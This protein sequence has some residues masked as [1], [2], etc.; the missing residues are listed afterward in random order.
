MAYLMSS[1]EIVVVNVRLPSFYGKRISDINDILT[2]CVMITKI[3]TRNN[4]IT[5]SSFWL[6]VHHETRMTVFITTGKCNGTSSHCWESP[7]LSSPNWS[8]RWTLKDHYKL[9]NMYSND[10]IIQEDILDSNYSSTLGV[11][12]KNS[13][14]KLML[15]VQVLWSFL[16]IL[17]LTS[18][19]FFLFFF[20]WVF[21]IVWSNDLILVYLLISK[22]NAIIYFRDYLNI[23]YSW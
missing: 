18:F 5:W 13:Y 10:G 12:S 23:I 14:L 16:L 8:A 19:K 17:S 4:F 2:F 11:R 6:M 7:Q 21:S 9:M 22:L 15:Q 3:Q 20:I 1:G